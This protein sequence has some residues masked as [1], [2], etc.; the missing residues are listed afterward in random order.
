MSY[1][2][3]Q[4]AA[5]I[6]VYYKKG[7]DRLAQA[8]HASGRTIYSTGGTAE[9]LTK[10]G[11]P[12]IEVSSLTQFPEMMGGRLKTL[13]PMVFGPI[14]GRTSVLSDIKSMQ[15]H[16]MPLID[17]VV[18][19]LYPFNEEVEKGANTTHQNIIEKIDI[20][21]P[22]LIRAAAKNYERVS[23][24]CDPRHY[25]VLADLIE[26]GAGISHDQREDW[27]GQAFDLTS[28]YDEPIGSYFAR[29]RLARQETVTGA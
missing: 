17:I 13:H 18:V 29:R 1:N 2:I 23:V 10:I 4:P 15:D 26:K 6:S 9:H 27:A 22:S 8:I 3:T 19:N 24:V 14:L 21:G 20:G 25:D 16:K 7:I 12:I 5:L 28:G 11:I